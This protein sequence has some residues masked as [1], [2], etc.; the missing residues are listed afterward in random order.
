MEQIGTLKTTK[1]DKEDVREAL[2][3]KGDEEV[4]NEKVSLE[5][6]LGVSNGLSKTVQDVHHWVS[7]QVQE[8]LRVTQ[9]FDYFHGK[10]ESRKNLF[11][12]FDHNFQ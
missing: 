7:Q 6:V 4:L 1:A 12:Y 8:L 10:R 3:L 9:R 5:Q 11:V 2:A